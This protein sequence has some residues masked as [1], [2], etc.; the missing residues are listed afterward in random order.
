M[1]LQLARRTR[2]LMLMVPAGPESGFRNVPPGRGP[3]AK[4]AGWRSETM[5]M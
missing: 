1:A 2:I 3:P 5:L 4:T